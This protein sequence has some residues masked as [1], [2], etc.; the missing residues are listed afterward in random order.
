[1]GFADLICERSQKP[2][3]NTACSKNNGL[4]LN[5][6]LHKLE[7]LSE[8]FNRIIFKFYYRVIL[9]W[10]PLGPNSINICFKT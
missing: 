10:N 2:F 7:S 3:E 4:N 1:M 5:Y 6:V 9:K 8:F